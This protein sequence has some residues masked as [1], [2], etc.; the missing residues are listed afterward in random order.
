MTTVRTHDFQQTETLDRQYVP[1]LHVALDTFARRGCLELST[2]L[3]RSTQLTVLSSRELSWR[4][5]TPLLG[6]RPYLATFNLEPLN[7]TV[8][9]SLSFETVVR[10]L[11]YRL[12]GGTQPTFTGHTD[13]TDTDF[14]L[15]GSVVEPLQ[16]ELAD[17]LSRVKEVTAIPVSQD[18]S[19]Q[20]VQ[21]A[22]PNEMFFVA[23]FQLSIGDDAP[24][25]MILFLPFHLVRQMTEAIRLGAR[26]RDDATSLVD[27]AVVTQANLDLWLEFPSVKLTSTEVSE[28]K[29]GDVIRL[30]HPLSQPLDLRAEGVLVA[31]AA[32]GAIGSKV[33][34]SILEEVSKGDD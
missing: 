12:G 30:F 6:E 19:A 9:L 25:E 32:Q 27:E 7:G 4:E 8:I 13:L 2:S 22:G 5:A 14:A 33:V 21:L 16:R 10:I 3:R 26:G 34:C 20:F 18:S 24:V 17:S 23:T 11:D 31:R 15:L 29:V 1:P 28:L